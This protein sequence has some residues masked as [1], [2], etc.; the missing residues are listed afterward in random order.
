MIGP[1]VLDPTYATIRLIDALLGKDTLTPHLEADI[2]Y[3]PK[4]R[5]T[6]GGPIENSVPIPAS[7]VRFRGTETILAY[8]ATGE[9]LLHQ[10]GN[11]KGGA[12]CAEDKNPEKIAES[13]F[14]VEYASLF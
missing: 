6:T 13:S 2:K 1:T 7:M 11:F 10:S 5:E 4:G 12:L 3:R 9:R 14:Q 8:F